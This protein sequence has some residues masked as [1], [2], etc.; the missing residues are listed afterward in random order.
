MRYLFSGAFILKVTHL[1][2]TFLFNLLPFLPL[3]MSVDAEQKGLD[4]IQ[5]GET[6]YN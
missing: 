5:Y 3:G 2:V 1:V 4:T 6:V